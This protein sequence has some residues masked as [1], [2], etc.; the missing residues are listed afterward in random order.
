MAAAG[1]SRPGVINQRVGR[2]FVR[3]RWPGVLTFAAISEVA[4]RA[5][6]VGWTCRADMVFEFTKNREVLLNL[7]SEVDETHHGQTPHART[8]LDIRSHIH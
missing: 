2:V 4:V 8:P 3:V 5:G 6:G 1:R 7:S